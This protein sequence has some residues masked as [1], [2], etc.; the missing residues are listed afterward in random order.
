MI[1]PRGITLQGR[2]RPSSFTVLQVALKLFSPACAESTQNGGGYVKHG[3][4][5]HHVAVLSH[6][7]AIGKNMTA[8]VL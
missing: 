4:P 1:P 7:D 2:I 8:L 5:K 6:K 3:T